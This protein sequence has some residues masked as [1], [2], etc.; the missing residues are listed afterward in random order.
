MFDNFTIYEDGQVISVKDN[1]NGYNICAVTEKSFT[2][3][4]VKK[5]DFSRTIH[6][7]L[8]SLEIKGSKPLEVYRK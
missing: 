8:D 6:K 5:N 7:Y 3:M 2:D 4:N 1:G